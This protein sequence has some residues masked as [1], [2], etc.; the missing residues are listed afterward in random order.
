VRSIINAKKSGKKF[1]VFVAESRPLFEGRKTYQKIDEEGVDA[2]LIADFSSF[3]FL[4]RIDMVL[5]GADT[6]C[7]DRVVNK[8]GTKGLAISAFEYGIPVYVLAEES[9]FLPTK[10]GKS[11]KIIENDPKELFKDD[12]YNYK[13]IN[14][15]FDT[16]P[17]KYLTEI[18]TENG[19]TSCDSVRNSL[20]TM[21]VSKS[22][23]HQD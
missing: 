23:M 1:K 22:L 9:K 2:V 5:V 10:L 20:V 17:F 21:K 16:T 18:I 4:D 6:I 11:P 12:A 8:I 19:L 14:I 3:H 7:L 13:A 15:Y